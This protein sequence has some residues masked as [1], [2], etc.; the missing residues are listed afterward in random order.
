MSGFYLER[1]VNLSS[2]I[3]LNTPFYLVRLFFLKK[4]INLEMSFFLKVKPKWII[5]ETEKKFNMHF[6]M[7]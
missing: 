4:Y 6:I 1:L 3:D 7:E 5:Y 2:I